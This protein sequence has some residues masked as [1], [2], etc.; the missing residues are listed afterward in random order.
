MT[1]ISIQWLTFSVLDECLIT[2]CEDYNY[3]CRNRRNIFSKGNSFKEWLN[4]E[5]E[6][7]P[8]FKRRKKLTGW[9]NTK[10]I[11]SNDLDGDGT[12][13]YDYLAKEE[14]NCE[15]LI[16]MVEF[17]GIKEPSSKLLTTLLKSTKFLN[18]LF[19]NLHST[20]V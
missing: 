3:I 10:V 7:S 9:R 13:E 6:K 20:W 8:S 4:K 1:I 18:F 11:K 12:I 14:P 5:K 15:I 2:I 19:F 16:K 17:M